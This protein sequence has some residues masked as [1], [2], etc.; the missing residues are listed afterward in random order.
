MQGKHISDIV[1]P[2]G[3]KKTALKTFAAQ[4][5]PKENSLVIFK[6]MYTSY[7]ENNKKKKKKSLK[8]YEFVK[9]KSC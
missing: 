4:K 5:N 9:A 2:T 6:S 3:W 8:R 7:R 1:Q